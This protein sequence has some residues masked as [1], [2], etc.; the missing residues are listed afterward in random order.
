MAFTKDFKK[1]ILPFPNSIGMHD[2]WI[3][4]CSIIFG[5]IVFIDK[6]LLYYR[7]HDSNFTLALNTKI[8][9]KLFWRVS[10]ISNLILRFIKLK[11]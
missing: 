7:R 6:K 2:W 9:T 10:L 5:K 4:I 1:T 11:K 8:S 3:G